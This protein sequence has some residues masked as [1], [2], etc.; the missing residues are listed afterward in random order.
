VVNSV[1]TSGQKST[2]IR[3][4]RFY[5]AVGKAEDSSTWLVHQLPLR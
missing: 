5:Y 4:R 2:A 3:L 1:Q